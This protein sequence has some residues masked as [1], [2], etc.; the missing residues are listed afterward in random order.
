MTSRTTYRCAIYTRK[1]SEEGLDRDF[2]SLKAQREACEAYARSQK[3]EGW[4]V[5]SKRYD[6][7]GI[8]GG[9]MERPALQ[10]LL[11]DVEEGR[12]EIVLVYKIDR[13]TRSLTDFAKIV[14]VFEAQNVSFVSVTQQFNTTTSMGRLTLNVLL[15][16]AQFE[17]EVT[18]E[19]IRDKIAASKKKGMWMGGLPP[20]GYDVKDRG[21]VVNVKEA[22]AVAQLFN[23]Y[24]EVRSVSKLHQ[25]AQD[26]QLRTKIRGQ[27]PNRGGRPF[28]RGHLYRILSNPI[29][30]GEVAHHGTRY[31]GLHKAIIDRPTWGAV[32]ALLATQA[33]DRRGPTNSREPS[34]LTGLVFDETGDRLSPVHATKAGLRYRYYVSRRLANGGDGDGR[35]WRLPARELESRLI[36][37]VCSLLRDR[38]RLVTKLGA[39]GLHPNAL[40]AL[41]SAASELAA[42]LESGPLNDRRRILQTMLHRVELASGELRLR[43]DLDKTWKLLSAQDNSL[44]DQ[45]PAAGLL[46]LTISISLKRRG[47]EAKL[48]IGSD[49]A[50]NTPNRDE[51][52]IRLVAKAH[53]WFRELT[54]GKIA[55]IDAIAM[56]ERLDAGDV[57]RFLGLAFLAPDLVKAILE[58]QQP[59]ELTAERLKRATPLPLAWSEQRKALG[60][61]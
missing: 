52:L 18:A 25:H 16:F 6:D 1:S 13:L 49:R 51:N 56:R 20:L 48:V 35:G 15:S 50:G 45:Q 7:G 53:D 41:L 2:N 34:L 8:S 40:R 54:T 57:S 12:I 11:G 37:S 22:A 39:S 36:A 10:E 44:S 55:S 17:R 28:S 24:L 47:V 46:D 59:V 23:L 26:L 38:S 31:P 30:V 14:Q 27:G 4:K 21:L 9:T 32:Q 33:P 61:A 43:L 60:F 42:L 5:I 19:R 58:G 29:Y 3:H